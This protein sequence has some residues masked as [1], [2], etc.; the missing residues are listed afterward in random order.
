VST[1][2]LKRF[3]AFIT[4]AA[5]VYLGTKRHIDKSFIKQKLHF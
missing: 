1:F 3:P 2:D 5:F 4:S